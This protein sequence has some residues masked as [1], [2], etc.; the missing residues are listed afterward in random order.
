MAESGFGTFVCSMC[1]GTFDKGRPDDVALSESA[2]VYGHNDFADLAVV[3]DDCHQRMQA[4]YPVSMFEEDMA[5]GIE[6][7]ITLP[8]TDRPPSA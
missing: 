4:A 6:R 7:R 2:A 1:N 5:A 8:P 3:C